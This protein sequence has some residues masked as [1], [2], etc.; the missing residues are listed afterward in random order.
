MEFL[1]YLE[2]THY[3]SRKSFYKKAAVFRDDK[4]HL[5]LKSYNTIVA[6]ITDAMMSEYNIPKVIVHGWYSA[7]T[8]RHINEF[9]AQN[10]FFPMSKK[11]MEKC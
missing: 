6:E 2:P 1:Y 3:D 10:G 5:L 7:T 11:E 4:G 9:L 8:A